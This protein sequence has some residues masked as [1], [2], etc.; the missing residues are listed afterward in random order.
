VVVNH[1]TPGS[2]ITSLWICWEFWEQRT[3]TFSSSEVEQII[4]RANEQCAMLYRM[5]AGAGL[6]KANAITQLL[7]TIKAVMPN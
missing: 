5:L 6:I 3:P 7:P 4:S 1:S 2:V